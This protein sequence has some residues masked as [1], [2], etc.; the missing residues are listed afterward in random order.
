MAAEREGKPFD[1]LM[2]D[3]VM[4][5]MHGDEVRGRLRPRA[6]RDMR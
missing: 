3:I 1:L 2:L 5:G 4:C 6:G